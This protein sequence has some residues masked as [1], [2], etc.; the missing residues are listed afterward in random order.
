MTLMLEN[1]RELP[2]MVDLASELGAD[3]LWAQH[4]VMR[5]DHS[6]DNW[7]I[8]VGGWTFVYNDQHLSNDP[9]LSNEM[10]RQARERLQFRARSGALAAGA[11]QCTRRSLDGAFISFAS[12]AGG[13]RRT[14]T[15]AP[16]SDLRLSSAM[17]VVVCRTAWSRTTMLFCIGIGRQS[18]RRVDRRYLERPNHGPLA[19]LHSRWLHRSGMPERRLQV[20][21]R[22]REHIWPRRL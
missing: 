22:H 5:N 12:L 3:A 14:T 2:M 4:L 17:G 15:V 21:S 9:C 19:E 7:R 20:R 18:Q 6:Q 13:A 16:P 11:E 10:V 8:T 1:I